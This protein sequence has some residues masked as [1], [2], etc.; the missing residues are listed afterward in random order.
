MA[1]SY[2]T[3]LAA[4]RERLGEKAV[5]HSEAVAGTAVELAQAYDA[6]ETA[7]RI[8]GL[9]HDWAREDDDDAL[10]A[11]AEG[12]DAG[13]DEVDQAVPYLLHAHAGARALRE[14]FP[15]ISGEIIDAVAHH[16]I[17]AQEMT[18]LDRIVYV[19][20]MIE[21]TRTFKGVEK[22]R[23]AVGEVTLE[24]LFARAYARSLLHI[25]NKRK[26]L[27]PRSVAVW[28]SIVSASERSQDASGALTPEDL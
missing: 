19:A 28:N 26:H 25:V 13:I 17:G 10:L 24:E 1:L 11:S 5:A 2:E 22:L 6:D 8:A 12:S 7:A 18:D 15:E 4:L 16:T 20:D 9:L 21:P 3:A 27:H 14:E 23:A